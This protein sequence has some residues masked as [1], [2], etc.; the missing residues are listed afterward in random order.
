[1]D[2][3]RAIAILLN[4][5]EEWD[6]K[7]KKDGYEY[8]ENFVDVMQGLN[9]ELF[10]LSL[11]ELPKDRN[12]KKVQ[13]QLGTVISSKKHLICPKGKFQ[14]STFLQKT[15]VS[16][17]CNHTFAE[18]SELIAFFTK[19]SLSAKQVERLCHHYGESLEQLPL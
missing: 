5:L 13:T 18:S 19:S 14:Q 7:S 9:H 12:K 11:G 17:G 15:A 6:T 4:K 3:Q 10:Q 16:L 8:E 1:M 2:K